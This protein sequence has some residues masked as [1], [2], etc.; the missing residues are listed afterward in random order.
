[1]GEDRFG[2]C[3]ESGILTS[4][5]VRPRFYGRR[6]GK[7]LRPGRQFL[8]DGLLPTIRVAVPE[9][10]KTLDP[11][12]LFE[13]ASRD[14]MFDRVW[15]EIG[16]GGGEHLIHQATTNADVGIIGFEPFVNGV[17]TALRAIADHDIQNIRIF[18][19]DARLLLPQIREKSIDRVFVLFPDPW[20]KQRHWNR[21]VF[22]T[23]LLDTLA[24]LMKDGAE[25]RFAS[26]HMGYVRWALR[27]VQMHP[28]FDWMASRPEDWRNRP[29][30]AI[31]T[32]Y[33]A[34][35]RGK[36]DAPVFLSFQRLT[37]AKID[38]T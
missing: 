21:R 17:S 10:G 16:F 22:N 11:L 36:G 24:F 5:S 26:D 2:R 34:K 12:T 14:A 38:A 9:E 35:G 37:R 8:V 25:L 1:V 19:D 33:E 28:Y 13:T 7:P 23:V 31:E 29:E 6:R 3:I 15:I 20:P 32:R 18:D 27:H 4:D 30:D